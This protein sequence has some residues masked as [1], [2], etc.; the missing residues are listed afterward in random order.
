[1]GTDDR[2]SKNS[3]VKCRNEDKSN[4]TYS[5]W[6]VVLG[7]ILG[8]D[9]VTRKSINEGEIKTLYGNV[10][11]SVSSKL[12][13][14]RVLSMKL[15]LLRRGSKRFLVHAPATVTLVLWPSSCM[16]AVMSNHLLVKSS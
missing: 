8:T 12:T 1:M 5:G 11:I 6:V 7:R 14:T 15:L 9:Q 16:L 4:K 3:L 2:N 10:E 13:E